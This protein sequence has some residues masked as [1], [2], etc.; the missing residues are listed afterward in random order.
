MNKKF[1]TLLLISSFN[2]L[3][4]QVTIRANFPSSVAPGTVLDVDVK[5]TKGNISNFAKYQMD[6][7]NGVVVSE[8]DSKTGNFTFENNRAKIVWVTIPGDNEFTLKFKIAVNANTASPVNITQK[9]FF[10]DNGAKREFEADP[11]S[12]TINEGTSP[13]SSIANANNTEPETKNEK[14]PVKDE[15][16]VVKETPKNDP[17]P[18]K[19]KEPVKAETPV[20][21]ETPKAPEKTAI[22][23]LVYKVQL[24]SSSAEPDKSKYNGAGKIQVSKEDGLYKVLSGNCNTREEAIKLKEELA[25]KGF[26]GFVVSYQNGVR[27][28]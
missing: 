6:V 23:G 28:K 9:F 22:T 20:V 11:I 1:I 10:L 2:F 3:I 19:E 21:K 4:S 16:P 26:N 13:K 25:A 15:T 27:V 7:P 8:I 5:I 17:P 18:V 24:G 12:V 14:Q